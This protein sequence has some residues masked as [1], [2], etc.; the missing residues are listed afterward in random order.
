M[1]ATSQHWSREDRRQA[2]LYLIMAHNRATFAELA[3]SFEV[4]QMTICRDVEHL[5]RLKR[6]TANFGS[7]HEPAVKR[8]ESSLRYRRMAPVAVDGHVRNVG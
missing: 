5:E 2:I 6:V 3:E 7:C 4:S 8:Y 1:D